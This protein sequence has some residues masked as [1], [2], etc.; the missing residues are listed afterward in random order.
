MRKIR[1]AVEG[2]EEAEAE[3]SLDLVAAAEW[4]GEKNRREAESNLPIPTYT[5]TTHR[6][7]LQYSLKC[8]SMCSPIIPHY[9]KQDNPSSRF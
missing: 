7:Q 4:R 9:Q 6:E 1:I 3:L 8:G 2:R 5:C